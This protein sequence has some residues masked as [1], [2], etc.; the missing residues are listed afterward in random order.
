MSLMPRRRTCALRLRT[1][2]RRSSRDGVSW[3][4]LRG[5]TTCSA[6]AMLSNATQKRLPS[7]KCGRRASCLRMQSA[8]CTRLRPRSSTS[9]AAD[10]IDGNHGRDK[11]LRAQGRV[12]DHHGLQLPADAHVL[13]NGTGARGGQRTLFCFYLARQDGDRC[14]CFDLANSLTWMALTISPARSITRRPSLNLRKQRPSRSSPCGTCNRRPVPGP[15]RPGRRTRRATAHVTRRHCARQFHGFHERR[16]ATHRDRCA[17]TRMRRSRRT[18]CW[19]RM[20]ARMCSDAR[21][22][23]SRCA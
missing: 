6:S 22:C 19:W 9:A 3:R 12:R 18:G 20:R 23:A 7:S 5:G 21:A 8:R 2:R 13:D 10:K 11:H 4:R 1:R 16:R 15:R 14:C 17:R